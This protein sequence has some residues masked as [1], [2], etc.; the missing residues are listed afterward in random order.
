M[1]E[2]ASKN[3]YILR[4]LEKL[5]NNSYPIFLNKLE[6]EGPVVLPNV[7]TLAFVLEKITSTMSQNWRFLKVCNEIWSE[8]D[9]LP[10]LVT[11]TLSQGNIFSLAKAL[12]IEQVIKRR[13]QVFETRHLR[14]GRLQ[15]K[16]L[17]HIVDFPLRFEKCKSN[18]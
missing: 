12:S 11:Y 10:K 1:G 2:N 13:L 5:Q 3:V 15:K 8:Y 6:Q 16:K 9:N 7:I 14:E 18:H 4:A 17:Y